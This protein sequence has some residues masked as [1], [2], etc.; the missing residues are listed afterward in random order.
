MSL[1]P[2]T[3][4]AGGLLSTPP[5]LQAPALARVRHGFF[6]REGGVSTGIYTSLNAGTGSNDDPDAVRENR[7]RIAAA[8][9]A[10]HLIGVHQ[11]HSPDAVFA[12]GP[13]PQQR[14][15][16]DALVTTT[17]GLVISVLTADCAPVLLADAEAGVVAAAHA[18]WK[19]ALSG[20]L[21]AT[22]AL[23]RQHGARAIVAAI[24]PTIHQPSY[25]VGP[26]FEAKFLAAAPANARFFAPGANGRAHFDLPAFCAAQLK[27]LGVA[28]EILPHD[29]YAAPE[30]WHS[31]R[32]A[33]HR[34]EPDYGRN[35]AAIAL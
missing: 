6:G 17:P 19:G 3:A 30:R 31:C 26:E 34:G 21:G 27:A 1:Q 12:L 28:A 10:D 8:F 4:A 24:G 23:M 20:V 32:R 13:W 18:G 35:C 7:R 25:E 14:P 15:H 5:A 11:V 29:T 16:A 9:A 33:A 2:Q 22:V